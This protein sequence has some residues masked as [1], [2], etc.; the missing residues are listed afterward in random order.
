[1]KKVKQTITVDAILEDEAWPAEKLWQAVEELCE[2][3]NTVYMPDKRVGTHK[4][5]RC[6]NR[7]KKWS[8]E[9][10]ASPINR[11]I[12]SQFDDIFQEYS[13]VEPLKFTRGGLFFDNDEKGK[14][15]W[16]Y[17]YGG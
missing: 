16:R 11:E 9:I 1:M 7:M 12:L 5:K 10:V 8:D 2:D 4:R 13:G 14:L 15:R 3:W 6:I 17:Y